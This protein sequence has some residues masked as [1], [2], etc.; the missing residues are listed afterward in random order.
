MFQQMNKGQGRLVLVIIIIFIHTGLIC[1]ETFS[2][3]LTISGYVENSQSGERL[4]GANIWDGYTSK[5]S[6]SNSYGFFSLT[7]PSGY[8]S[9]TA[10]YVGYE[11]FHEE[12]I[13]KSD[14]V[15]VIALE[16]TLE[17]E[18][19]TV[20]GNKSEGSPGSSRMSFINLP[21]KTIKTLPV[22]L[23]ETDVLK[24]LQLLPGI[25]SG[26]EGTSALY[27]RG[28]G[29]DQNLI[30]IDGVPIYNPTHLFGFVS[31]FNTDLIK[32]I[33]ITKGGFPARYGSRLSSVVDIRCKE[34]NSK[35]L[36][37]Q[38]SIGLVSAKLMLE[39]P[40]VK[41]KMSFLFSGRRYYLDLLKKPIKKIDD[42]IPDYYFHDLTGKLSFKLSGKNNI[43]LNYYSNRDRGT[44]EEI[45]TDVDEVYSC[46][47][48][49]ASDYGWDTD[50]LAMHWNH[51]FISNLFFHG[52]L[53]YQKYKTF[54][55]HYQIETTTEL[56]TD[57]V[58][59]RTYFAGYHSLI[60]DISA[61]ADFDYIPSSNHTIRFGF[62]YT[63]HV[64][65]PGVNVYTV[66]NQDSITISND[67]DN[68]QRIPAGEAGFYLEDD[69]SIGNIVKLN[70]GLRFSGFYV[71]KRWYLSPEPRVSARFLIGPAWSVKCAWSRMNQY[72]HL[73]S[74]AR[75]GLTTDL[76][77]PATGRISP[78]TSV[79]YAIGTV[80]TL[81][82]AVNISIEGYYKLMDKIIEYKEGASYMN[83][84]DWQDLVEIGEGRAYGIEFLVEKTKGKT[85]GWLGYTLSRSERQFE[86]ICFGKVFPYRYDRTHDIS[87]VLMH[88]FNEKTDAAVTWVYGTGNAVTFWT[89][90]FFGI[91]YFEHRNNIRMPAYH[92]LDVSL[93]RHKK[94]KWGEQTWSVG[95]YNTYN[96]INP[97]Y[98]KY[99]D[100]PINPR[101]I[102]VGLFPILPSVA[103]NFK[104]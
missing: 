31:M 45:H 1:R 99:D 86:N 24:T 25:Q 67:S 13:I 15:I 77:V 92:R 21:V 69:F 102:M 66:T 8:M 83:E 49:E 61:G 68:R 94:K 5:G 95:I 58:T 76:W 32:D 56:N 64:Y 16:P 26:T 29:P 91:N 87:I 103:Y 27:V 101:I 14:T 12:M 100:D 9:I 85:T 2:Q 78:Q 52:N 4:I 79:Q 48:K 7:L 3:N 35:E 71:G 33:S 63:G 34:G 44:T 97:F 55:D 59:A 89:E 50:I 82:K 60:R 37:G 73:L 51:L 47:R 23:G 65:D 98:L 93:N 22:L 75:I 41:D 72:V 104:F 10:S 28:G 81:K 6:V 96:R 19:V 42:A 70:T 80:F 53:Y 39:G 43:Y 46:K 38:G 20:I 90:K 74:S 54:S 40:L 36:K 30:L 88:R 84:N 11:T 62:S 57:S 18:E 17:I